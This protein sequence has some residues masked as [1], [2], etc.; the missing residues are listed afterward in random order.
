[1]LSEMTKKL[2]E[3]RQQEDVGKKRVQGLIEEKREGKE[4]GGQRGQGR[5]RRK[6]RRRKTQKANV[7]EK[8]ER[9]EKEEGAHSLLPHLPPD[10]T[11]HP[12]S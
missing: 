12:A 8:R 6:G 9:E 3:V 2:E 4:R 5:E 1:M 7:G 10:H 11:L